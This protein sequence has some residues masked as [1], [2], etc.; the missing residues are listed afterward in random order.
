[1]KIDKWIYRA[2]FP[3][4]EGMFEKI[5]A[6]LG[7]KLFVWQKTFIVTGIFRQYGKTTGRS[8]NADRLHNKTNERKGKIL[9]RRNQKNTRAVT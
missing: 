6:A 5:E 9:Q 7:F 8:R 3:E 4:Y 1:M 2:V